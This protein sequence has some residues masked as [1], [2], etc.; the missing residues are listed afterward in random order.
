M[1]TKESL[2]RA[3]RDHAQRYDMQQQSR[4][5]ANLWATIEAM[6]CFQT[7]QHILL[8]WSL[9]GEVESHA[10]CARWAVDHAVY[11]P[12]MCGQTLELGRY[13]DPAALCPARFGVMEPRNGVRIDPQQVDLMIVP[14][15]GYDPQGRRLGHGKGFYDRLLQPYPEAISAQRT[16]SPFKIG[17]CFDYQ[18]F[19]EI[20]TEAHD[21]PVDCVVC[22]ALDE[23]RCFQRP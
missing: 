13:T 18:L 16:G 21:V 1:P 15:V 9:P 10:V 11:L 14:A 5:A 20:P 17:V 4:I 7:A 8:Y 22:G 3:V 2:R 12:I 23:V 19:P 6:P